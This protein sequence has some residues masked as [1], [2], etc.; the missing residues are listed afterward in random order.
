ME[1]TRN[2]LDN[3]KIR[4]SWGKLGNNGTN[5]PKESKYDYKYQSTYSL[6]NYSFGGLQAPGSASTVI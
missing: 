6:S 5:D 2:W 1:S 4:A 3:L